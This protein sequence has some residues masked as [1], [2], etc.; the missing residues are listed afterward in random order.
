MLQ[1]NKLL[2]YFQVL[3]H[4]CRPSL[5][6][7]SRN[8]KGLWPFLLYVASSSL[9]FRFQ[10]KCHLKWSLQDAFLIPKGAL[11]EDQVM[12]FCN[13]LSPSLR[14]PLDYKVRA[15]TIF[16][17]SHLILE[18]GR[19]SALCWINEQRWI[20][21]RNPNWNHLLEV[22]NGKLGRYVKDPD[23]PRVLETVL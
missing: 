8:P 20:R 22:K 2:L 14:P 11:L 3:R 4:L 13:C 17:N 23:S 9:S 16:V 10:V 21:G 1:V 7:Q 6:S 15:G 12:L 19:H 5:F 18:H